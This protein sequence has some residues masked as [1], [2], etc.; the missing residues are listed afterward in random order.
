MK[1]IFGTYIRLFTVTFIVSR[2]P[3]QAV[4]RSRFTFAKYIK[5]ALRVTMFMFLQNI[6]VV[7][8]ILQKK[9]VTNGI[10]NSVMAGF[11]CWVEMLQV[12]KES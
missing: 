8:L 5:I 9:A 12:N 2:S 1:K 4:F 10:P 11:E 3:H 6:T 7:L